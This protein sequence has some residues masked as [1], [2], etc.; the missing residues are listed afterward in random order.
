MARCPCVRLK[1][2]LPVK[3]SNRCWY[4][5]LVVTLLVGICIS[6][7]VMPLLKLS[8]YIIAQYNPKHERDFVIQDLRQ[9]E[10]VLT[11][12][13]PTNMKTQRLVENKRDG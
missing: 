5:A 10:S 6:Y 9:S 12:T 1:L 3:K 11:I 2:D 7:V 4:Q 13:T 8:T